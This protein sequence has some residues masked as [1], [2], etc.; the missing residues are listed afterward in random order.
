MVRSSITSAFCL[1]V[2]VASLAFGNTTATF[3]LTGTNEGANLG[4]VYTSPYF[5]SIETGTTTVSTAAICDD[6]SDDSY[7]GESWTANVTNYSNLSS[8]NSTVMW[9]GTTWQGQTLSQAQEYMAVALLTEDLLPIYSSNPTLAGEYGY[10][11]W[12]L[13]YPDSESGSQSPESYLNSSGIPGIWSAVEGLVNSAV[14]NVVGPGSKV[15]LSQFGSVAIYSYD[16][17]AGLPTGCG[18]TCPPPPQ[19]FI[20]VGMPEPSMPLSLLFYFSAL[21]CLV[22]VFRRRVIKSDR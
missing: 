6:F 20:V 18:N 10:A 17:A 15:S 13:T 4:G 8:F 3:T 9:T 16:S 21:T 2:S 12:A 22:I 14:T 5:A 19:E 11:V 1:F 7:L